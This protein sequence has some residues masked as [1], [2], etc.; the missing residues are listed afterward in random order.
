MKLQSLVLQ[1]V[2]AYFGRNQFDF[3]H[4]SPSKNIILFGGKNGAGKT[5]ILDSLKLV[6]FGPLAFGLRSETEKYWSIVR[7]MF[8]KKAKELKENK[9]GIS[10]EFS[11]VEDLQENYYSIT[12]IWEINQEKLKET[13]QIIKN[14]RE[15]KGI[16]LEVFQS[17]LREE[18]P[19]Y[20][21]ELILMDGEEISRIVAEQ[22]LEEYLKHVSNIVFN[23]DRFE[24]LEK[25]LY[26]FQTQKSSKTELTEDEDK[27]QEMEQKY[28]QCQESIK[29][30][31]RKKVNL[32][33][34]LEEYEVELKRIRQEFEV[35]GGLRNEEREKL[36]AEEKEIEGKRKVNSEKLRRFITTYLPFYLNRNLLEKVINQMNQ[37][38]VVEAGSQVVS[39]LQE[40][41][42]YQLLVK[43]TKDTLSEVDQK[44]ISKLLGVVLQSLKEI[45]VDEELTF[46]HRASVSQQAEV[47]GLLQRLKQIQQEELIALYDENNQLLKEAQNIR[48]R[49]ELNNKAFD[50]QVLLDEIE[51]ASKKI[52]QLNIELNQI[53]E[54]IQNEKHDLE[55]IYKEKE[56]L[57]QKISKSSRMQS[58]FAL[59]SRIIELSKSFRKLQMQKKL[60]HVEMETIKIIKKLFRKKQYIHGLII[61]PDTFSVSLLDQSNNEIIKERLSAGEKALLVI[62]IVWAM[63]KVSKRKLPF[64]MD[65]LFGRLDVEHRKALSSHL[66]PYIGEQVIILATDSEVNK[67]VY[68]IISQYVSKEYTIEYDEEDQQV[69]ITP[70]QYFNFSK[71]ELTS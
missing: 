53:E 37:E 48:K 49:I 2:G 19:P 45:A 68:D 70:D 47:S 12:R 3:H 25:D 24:M 69:Y 26:I 52:E 59:S 67:E 33:R 39:F 27:L 66:L 44:Q 55:L 17:K 63:F 4:T 58:A 43:K 62:S 9:F 42:Q 35:Y 51:T 11:M 50:L 23:L 20:L 29:E 7:S 14:R 10:V 8:N 32:R 22:R 15:L 61:N 36:L 5:T 18:I 6:I 41:E 30:N 34:E 13:V 46:I 57:H 1:N 60:K 38:K 21:F 56:R 71:V 54:I 31:E 40:Q 28:L 16:D 65:T 64:V